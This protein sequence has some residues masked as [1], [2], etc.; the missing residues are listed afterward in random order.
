MLV[1][2]AGLVLIALVESWNIQNLSTGLEHLVTNEFVPLVKKDLQHVN[3]MEANIR[4][5]LAVDRHIHR[6]RIAESQALA[7]K[8]PENIQKA[9]TENIQNIASAARMIN[10]LKFMEGSEDLQ[11]RLKEFKNLFS[12]WQVITIR[13]ITF[14]KDPTKHDLA[15][16]IS[17]G[18]ATNLFNQ[19]ADKVDKITEIMTK[20]ISGLHKGFNETTDEAV[21]HAEEV[22]T[23]GRRGLWI[24][25]GIGG[26]VALL[27]LGV[28]M[29]IARSVIQPINKAI[30]QLSNTAEVT[31][32]A[33]MELSRTSSNIADAAS[34]Q[35]AAL[36]ETSSSLE[37]MRSRAQRNAKA[38]ANADSLAGEARTHASKGTQSMGRMLTAIEEIK[39]SSDETARIIKTIDEIAFQTN[40]LALNAAVEA[41]RA[42]DAGKGFAVVAEEVRNLAK[43]SA[44]AARSTN[45]LIALSQ[46]RAD[47]GVGVA[48]EVE[49]VFQE[50]NMANQQVEDLV[51]E[52]TLVAKEQAEAVNQV[53]MAVADM[54][55]TTQENS[56]SAANAADNSGRILTQAQMLTQMIDDFKSMI[57]GGRSQNSEL[58]DLDDDDILL[59]DFGEMEKENA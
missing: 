27:F 47:A 40:L 26:A 59:E 35:A 34:N 33:T 43:R 1:P 25:I 46:E 57:S 7:A 20:H 19:M 13:A 22:V 30:D 12:A 29:G 28:G 45:D 55:K 44:D 14:A 53:A 58:D 15:L 48:G 54:Q 9:Q 8:T 11:K 10:D 51:R 56:D 5:L 37:E 36:E 31:T 21:A 24:F 18:P 32:D 50:I 4:R 3:M 6:A 17:Y 38:T 49:T 41:A 39:N 42:G 16:N 2:L 23:S 52:V